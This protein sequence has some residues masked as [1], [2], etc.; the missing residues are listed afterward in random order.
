MIYRVLN[1]KSKNWWWHLELRRQGK[2]Q[3]ARSLER[4]DIRRCIQTL[5][6]ALSSGGI[7][8]AGENKYLLEY[9]RD[10]NR[11][12]VSGYDAAD[13]G[14][15]LC[16]QIVGVLMCDYR[17]L[18]ETVVTRSILGYEGIDRVRFLVENGAKV[19]NME[20]LNGTH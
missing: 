11:C 20:K 3:E 5:R 15:P 12:W 16:C 17:G 19:Y 7:C 8:F 1:R 10:G 2:T 9:Q 6:S 13:E 14:M 4:K 18:S